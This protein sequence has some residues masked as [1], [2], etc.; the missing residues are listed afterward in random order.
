MRYGGSKVKRFY[1]VRG[2]EATAKEGPMAPG[3]LLL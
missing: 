3:Q 1:D 2:K